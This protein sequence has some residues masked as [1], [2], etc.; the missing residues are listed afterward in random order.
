VTAEV[1]LQGIVSGLLM[2]FVYALIAAGLSLIFGLMEIVNFAHG[3]FL[4]LAMFS[5]YWAW[6]LWRLDPVLSLP[7]TAAAMFLLGFATYHGL[8][9][10]VLGAP[11]LAQIF[12]TFGLA[13]FL[14]SAAQ[15]IWGVDFHLVKDPLV[16]GRVSLSGLFI[17]LPQ[18]VASVGALL[19]FVFLNWFISR[20]ETGLAL[21]ATAQDRQAASLMGINTERMFALGWGIGAACVGVAGALLTIFFYVFPDVGASFALLAYVTVALGG[22]GNV[23]GT[24]VAGVVVGLI[25]VL[26]GLLIAPA[27]KYVA[28]FVLY[29]L[30]VLWRPQGL[31]GRF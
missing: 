15:A 28:V 4:M 25:E 27:L 6:A 5:T 16:Q 18:L 14:R 17:G 22:F 29:L 19:A 1:L 31:F 10:W 21:Q 9:R 8:I 7:L 26:G 12:A 23:P 11:M 20:T 30:V 24:L 2:G 3:E 13:I